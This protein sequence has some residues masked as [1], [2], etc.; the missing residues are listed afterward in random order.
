MV[1]REKGFK[2][3]KD[4]SDSRGSHFQ[5][6]KLQ[7]P[8][9]LFLYHL[10]YNHLQTSIWATSVTSGNNLF[11]SNI[12]FPIL[13]LNWFQYS[14]SLLPNLR[15][16]IVKKFIKLIGKKEIAILAAEKFSRTSVQRCPSSHSPPSRSW[17]SKPLPLER[18]GDRL[19]SSKNGKDGLS[20][21]LEGA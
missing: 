9:C 16:A 14:F 7:I 2:K 8:I 1:R 15:G 5:L 11:P 3:K 10:P 19:Y 13:K 4:I 6:E 12:F 21:F 17:P 20:L 18:Q